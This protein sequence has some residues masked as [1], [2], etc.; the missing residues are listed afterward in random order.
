MA[1]DPDRKLT[2]SYGT[3]LPEFVGT[4]D[5]EVFYD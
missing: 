4:G 1:F 2:M 5:R 3:G